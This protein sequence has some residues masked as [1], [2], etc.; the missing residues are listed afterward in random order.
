MLLPKVNNPNK[1]TEF[2]FIRLSNFTSKIIS[3]IVSNKLSPILPSLVSTN[4]SEFVKGRSIFEDI[5][6]A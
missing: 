6:V 1:L 4:P 5:M 2:S 3:K